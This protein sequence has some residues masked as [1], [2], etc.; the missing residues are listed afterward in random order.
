MRR[1][2]IHA[3]AKWL[4]RVAATVFL[5]Q[6]LI[7]LAMMSVE[8]NHA[9]MRADSAFLE[10]AEDFTRRDVAQAKSAEAEAAKEGKPVPSTPCPGRRRH[11]D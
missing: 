11:V 4:L 1:P 10:Q 9:D 8:A 2:T 6:C 5:L 7:S 3:V